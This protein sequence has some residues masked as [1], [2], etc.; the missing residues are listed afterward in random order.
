[1]EATWNQ[2]V[3][4]YI[5]QG[6]IHVSREEIERCAKI[7]SA[8]GPLFKACEQSIVG[9]FENGNQKFDRCGRCKKV[10]RHFPMSPVN[11]TITCLRRQSVIVVKIA[12]QAWKTHK[13]VCCAEGQHEPSLP[14]QEA[15]EGA[16]QR[17]SKEKPS[18]SLNE[19]LPYRCSVMLWTKLLPSYLT[20]F[21]AIITNES[22]FF[23]IV[24]K[25]VNGILY[26]VPKVA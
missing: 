26:D 12:R 25:C 2:L 8:N 10:N 3:D 21:V 5:N 15:I 16:V 23:D 7:D 22:T 6:Q 4:N 24:V 11:L 1:M 9:A 13:S 19:T 18:I 17:V 14:S 20:S